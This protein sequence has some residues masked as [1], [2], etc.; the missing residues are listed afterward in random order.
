MSKSRVVPAHQPVDLPLELGRL[1]LVAF[2]LA[3]EPRD[4]VETL[5]LTDRFLKLAYRQAAEKAFR[6]HGRIL[7]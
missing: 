1:A 7:E 4:L 2:K 3:L 5:L 6:Y